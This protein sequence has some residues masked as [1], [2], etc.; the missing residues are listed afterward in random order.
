MPLH[1]CRKVVCKGRGDRLGIVGRH[2]TA[3]CYPK[4]QRYLPPFSRPG[5]H[6]QQCRLRPSARPPGK[7]MHG[8]FISR[9]G[10]AKDTTCPQSLAEP[11]ERLKQPAE[12]TNLVSRRGCDV[13]MRRQVPRRPSS[14]SSPAWKE[15]RR[16]KGESINSS[17]TKSLC[18]TDLRQHSTARRLR[19]IELHC[20]A[21]DNDTQTH[22]PGQRRSLS[23]CFDVSRA[24]RLF[25]NAILS[26]HI[27]ACVVAVPLVNCIEGWQTYWQ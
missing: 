9:I 16:P 7:P 8:C 27:Y 15:Q 23:F 25:S 11:A 19:S 21:Y 26:L 17:H 12:A 13:D 3:A 6:R 18:T 14:G 22:S 5:Y 24:T 10:S 4:Y 1:A 20:T 2:A